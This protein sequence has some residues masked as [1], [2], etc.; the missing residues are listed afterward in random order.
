[1]DNLTAKQKSKTKH[2]SFSSVWESFCS[3]TCACATE[4]TPH[5]NFPGRNIPE[6]PAVKSALLSSCSYQNRRSAINDLQADK[7]NPDNVAVSQQ[8]SHSRERPVMLSKS[9]P[10][11]SKVQK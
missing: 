1:M 2:L 7:A 6:F 3:R 11:L 10:P 4:I 8:K 9:F 5:F